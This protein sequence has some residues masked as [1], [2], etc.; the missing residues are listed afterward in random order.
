MRLYLSS[1]RIGG[2]AGRLLALGASRRTALVPN[3]L[4]GLPSDVRDAGLQRDISDLGQVGLEVSEVD[5]RHPDAAERLSGY[6]IVWVRGGNVFVLRRVLA[7]TGTDQVLT[8]LIRGDAIVYAG[9][10]A[11]ACVLAP[12]LTGLEGIDDIT[13]VADPVATGLG[14][15][16]R[17]FVPHVRSPGHPE[18]AA[19]DALAAR[20]QAAG[21]AHWALRDGDVLVID[22]KTI[23]LLRNDPAAP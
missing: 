23:E 2:F 5:L 7:D 20:Y 22:G 3:A 6:D 18:T 17:P 11:G 16:D 19:C 14:L 15:L 9:Y 13:A 12:D 8:D 1:F 4:D 21:Q 10:S